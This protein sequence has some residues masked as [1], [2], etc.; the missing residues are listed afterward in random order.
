MAPIQPG[1]LPS[2]DDLRR[3]RH[4][5]DGAGRDDRRWRAVP[6]GPSALG[7]A[8]VWCPGNTRCGGKDRLGRISKRGDGYIRRL[9]VHGARTVLRWR[10]AKPVHGARLDRPAPGAAA[11]ERRAGRPWPIR[12]AGLASTSRTMLRVR[13]YVGPWS[14]RTGLLQTQEG[15]LTTMVKKARSSPSAETPAC[16]ARFLRCEPLA[17]DHAVRPAWIGSV[18]AAGVNFSLAEIVWAEDAFSTDHFRGLDSCTLGRRGYR[19]RASERDCYDGRPRE[20]QRLTPRSRHSVKDVELTDPG[21]EAATAHLAGG[22]LNCLVQN[23]SRYCASDHLRGPSWPRPPGDLAESAAGS[24]T[25]VGRRRGAL[26][27]CPK[28]ERP[29]RNVIGFALGSPAG[30]QDPRSAVI[31]RPV[32]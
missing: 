27:R 5:R 21:G 3:R 28:A 16:H 1:E 11:D 23:R 18:P 29:S 10:R 17:R 24:G 25:W 32:S 9:L 31:R 19:W 13:T 2:C 12:S 7:L 30:H 15:E 22:Q 4:H 26:W 8:Q 14:R 20:A 6:L